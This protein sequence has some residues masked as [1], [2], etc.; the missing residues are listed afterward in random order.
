MSDEQKILDCFGK[1]PLSVT[2]LAKRT[3]MSR[4]RIML[5]SKQ[6]RQVVPEEVGSGKQRV[7][8]FV[9]ASGVSEKSL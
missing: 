9:P 6:L 8:V 5:H 1:S 3:G 7:Q 4:K 2:T